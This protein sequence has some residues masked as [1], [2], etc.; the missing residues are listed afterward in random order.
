MLAGGEMARA[1]PSLLDSYLE[2]DALD[3][4]QPDAV[5]AVGIARARD[6]GRRVL[7]RGAR[8]TPHTWTNGIGL[9]ANLHLSA[10]IGG[11]PYPRVSL[12][13]TRLDA[14][15]RD[16]MLAEPLVPDADGCLA[17]PAAPGLGID[18]D[19]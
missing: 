17:V 18:L 10:G 13:P 16:F 2:A 3:V 5:L 12:R 7:R 1:R 15:R 9:L 8:F 19:G 6:F 4:Y 14:E 11:G